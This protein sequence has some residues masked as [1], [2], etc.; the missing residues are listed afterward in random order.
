MC[1][2]GTNGTNC[3][4]DI[5]ECA[6]K[7][8]MNNATCHDFL[9]GYNCTC[10]PGFSGKLF[11]VKCTAGGGANLISK[12]ATQRFKKKRLVHNPDVKTLNDRCFSR[13]M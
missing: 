10:L 5:N 6:T 8:C 12:A 3:Q 4:N 7:P 13:S 2:P 1:Q 11:K 9:N